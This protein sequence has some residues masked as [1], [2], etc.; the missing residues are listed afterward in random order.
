MTCTGGGSRVNPAPIAWWRRWTSR[1]R[2]R[3]ARD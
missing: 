1:S 3:R 2:A